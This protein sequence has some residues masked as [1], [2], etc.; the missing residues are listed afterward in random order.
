MKPTVATALSVA[1]VLVAAALAIAANTAV[2]AEP[3]TAP[4]S[5]LVG[6]QQIAGDPT[7]SGGSPTPAG[8]AVGARSFQ[9]GPAGTI[10]VDADGGLH[11]VDARPAAGWHFLG[12]EGSAGRVDAQFASE[13][14]ALTATAVLGPDGIEVSVARLG[15]DRAG[16][17]TNH[18][19][20]DHR[21][22]PEEWHDGDLDDD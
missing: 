19:D 5:G 16:P 10:T 13:D 20:A 9:V 15:G 1:G 11:V 21:G 17:P 4:P 12:Q 18:D 14:A 7:A 22:E 8:A 6:D 2:F 3:D